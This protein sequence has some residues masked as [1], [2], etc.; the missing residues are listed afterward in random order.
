MKQGCQLLGLAL[1]VVVSWIA[2]KSLCA[3]AG[4]VKQGGHGVQRGLAGLG[5]PKMSE[6][7][8]ENFL[9]EHGVR[10]GL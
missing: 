4:A 5:E 6:D 7:E 10:R 8:G 2:R 9:A 3:E 1:E